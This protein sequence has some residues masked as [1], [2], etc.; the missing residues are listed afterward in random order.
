M[1]HFGWICGIS[2][3]PL[4]SLGGQ[5][6]ASAVRERFL[7]APG[8]P[9]VACEAHVAVMLILYMRRVKSVVG[10]DVRRPD[11]P[12]SRGNIDARSTSRASV[13]VQLCAPRD[14]KGHAARVDAA[15][16]WGGLI[17][18]SSGRP[19]ARSRPQWHHL[20]ARRSE[21]AR[22]APGRVS[23]DAA[24]T[25]VRHTAPVSAYPR[26]GGL[27]AGSTAVSGDGH[28]RH[29]PEAEGGGRTAR[30]YRGRASHGRRA[31]V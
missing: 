25:D 23:H 11:P 13:A 20:A 28:E 15:L 18:V 6:D 29:T 3:A 8:E 7:A 16:V 30:Q 24:Q 9:P 27:V 2:R 22:S 17:A 5:P 19:Q 26:R 10:P 12:E 1:T 14:H 31:G 21:N 4:M